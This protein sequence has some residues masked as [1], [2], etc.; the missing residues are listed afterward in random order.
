MLKVVLLGYGELA[1]SLLLGLLKSRHKVVG[2]F[3]WENNPYNKSV[4][5][6]RDTFIPCPLTA[7]IRNKDLYEI[8]ADRANTENFACEIEKLQP[9]VILVGSWGE[10]LT[11]QT[12]KLPKTAF[13]NCHPSMLPSHRGSNPYASAIRNGETKTGVTFHLMSEKIDAGEI[14]LQKEIDILPEETGASLRKKCAFAAGSSVSE[15]LDK[16]EKAQLIPRK[17]DETMASYFPQLTPD[18]ASIDWNRHAVEIHNGIRG[19]YP[20]LECYTLHKD[21][22]LYIRSTKIIDL[23]QTTGFTPGIIIDKSEDSLLI[24]TAD[25][26]KA[27]LAENIKAYGFFGDYWTKFYISSF[28]KTG[29]CLQ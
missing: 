9:D 21:V 24:T 23:S 16:L 19:L 1:Q 11:G 27:I 13:I 3:R 10:I 28:V 29:D 17:Q 7:M 18:E 5:L 8:K 4:N 26:D 14:L 20:W 22:F 6:I 25:S 2:V 15:L 12:I